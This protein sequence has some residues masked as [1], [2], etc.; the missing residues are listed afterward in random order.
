LPWGHCT[1][2]A[3]IFDLDGFD[4]AFVQDEGDYCL[5]VVDSGG[6]L[7]AAM[8]G[9][10]NPESK[11][12]GSAVA[13]PKVPFRSMHAVATTDRAVYVFDSQNRRVVR[14]RLEAQAAEVAEV[15]L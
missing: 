5:K 9:Y 2:Q 4:R 10:G 12:P 13:V 15:R 7:I 8:G 14:I 11:G 1:C 6:N 3:C